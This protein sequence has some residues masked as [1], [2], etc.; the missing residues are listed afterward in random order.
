MVCCA[1]LS[2]SCF[3]A[4]GP[5]ASVAVCTTGTG[6]QL[7]RTRLAGHVADRLLRDPYADAG[8]LLHG[9]TRRRVVT[10]RVLRD[11]AASGRDG[12]AAGRS[13]GAGAARRAVSGR[14]TCCGA[15]SC[16]VVLLVCCAFY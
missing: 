9:S 8:A 14:A 12:G 15:F 7:I 6:E 5:H 1:S 2:P 3:A 10:D 4:D 11:V 16:A 13:L